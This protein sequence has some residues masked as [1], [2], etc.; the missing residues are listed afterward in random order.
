VLSCQLK[1]GKL[2]ADVRK[3][4]VVK[5]VFVN[6][7]TEMLPSG[8]NPEDL[9]AVYTKAK[10]ESRAA[11]LG[12]T[13]AATSSSKAHSSL[14][15]DRQLA[16]VFVEFDLTG[17]G[18]VDIEE[19]DKLAKT[20]R[21]IERKGTWDEKKN[22]TF[23]DKATRSASLHLAVSLLVPSMCPPQKPTSPHPCCCRWMLTAA[24]VLTRKNSSVISWSIGTEGWTT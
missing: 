13:A 23:F 3:G 24:A 22:R 7:Y 12:A 9:I 19:F 11:G 2:E 16:K 10:D 20:K 1:H 21:Q 15:R 5:R 6:F 8:A 4:V 14:E 18:I 17:D